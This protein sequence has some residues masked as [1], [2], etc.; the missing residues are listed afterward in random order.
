[1]S[2]ATWV[3]LAKFGLTVTGY[4]SADG[5]TWQALG[6]AT[7]P[8][9]GTLDIGLVA[10]SG[11]AHITASAVFTGFDLFFASGCGRCGNGG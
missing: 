4:S 5:V 3:R 11:T 7:L 9:G 2:G 1:M 8:Y 6:A 10:A